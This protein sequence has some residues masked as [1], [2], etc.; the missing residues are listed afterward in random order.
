[1]LT[2]I[3]AARGIFWTGASASV[4]TLPLAGGTPRVLYSGPSGM[5]SVAIANLY[6]GVDAS[7]TNGPEAVY[8]GLQYI[9]FGSAEAVGAEVVRIPLD[10]TT[11][12]VI[13][14]IQ[15]SVALGRIISAGYGVYFSLPPEVTGLGSGGIARIDRCGCTPH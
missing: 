2:G 6:L 14:Q 11:S 15:P 7:A 3:N 13:F 10:G 4:L 9:P 8:L 12:K 1:M 5:E